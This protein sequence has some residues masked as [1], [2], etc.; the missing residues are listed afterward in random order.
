MN[1]DLNRSS[2]GYLAD[3]HVGGA[4]V[5]EIGNPYKVHHA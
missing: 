2:A 4:S 3:F 1:T 5:N